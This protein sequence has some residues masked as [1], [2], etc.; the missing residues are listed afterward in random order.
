M[1]LTAIVTCM[2]FG[3]ISG[4]GPA[5]VA[6]IG[7]LT[8][9]AMVERGYDKFYFLMRSCRGRGLRGRDDPAVQ[10]IRGFAACRRYPS[11]TFSWPALFQACLPVLY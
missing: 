11:A 4:S 2:F 5:T 1:G 8:I 7:A 9:P 6:A 3:A 10:S